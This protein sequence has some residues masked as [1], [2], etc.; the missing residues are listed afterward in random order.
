MPTFELVFDAAGS[1]GVRGH[2]IGTPVF[3]TRETARPK[4]Y[5]W[6]QGRVMRLG[7]NH[8]LHVDHMFP[9]IDLGGNEPG[10]VLI[11]GFAAA[12]LLS[13]P[14]GPYTSGAW[15]AGVQT[16]DAS[17]LA[18]SNYWHV[19]VGAG[20]SV[21][22]QDGVATGGSARTTPG[23][24]TVNGPGHAYFTLNIPGTG[25][26]FAVSGT[27]EF[28]NLRN[29]IGIV[30]PSP[31]A[32]AAT[33]VAEFICTMP[34]TERIHSTGGASLEVKFVFPPVSALSGTTFREIV[35]LGDSTETNGLAIMVRTFGSGQWGVVPAIISG[36]TTFWTTSASLTVSPGLH[37][38]RVQWDGRLWLRAS[39][40]GAQITVPAPVQHP[41]L[42]SMSPP[43]AF[44]MDRVVV[45]A[46]PIYSMSGKLTAIRGAPGVGWDE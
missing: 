46:R 26:R 34:I 4:P 27:P 41:T 12:Q 2:G 39:S 42:A 1:G 40:G 35:R 3:T 30:V 25:L 7:Q 37:V 43:A 21:T 18:V 24:F 10:L 29:D 36:N 13:D 38:I 19:S 45:G 23:T 32:P 15:S 17:A 44:V 9:G 6:D 8:T 33:G 14:A 5:Y 20:G 11:P 22:V 31:H 16:L 28:V